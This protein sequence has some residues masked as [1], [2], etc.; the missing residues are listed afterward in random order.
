M[1]GKKMPGHTGNKRRTTT[2]LKIITVDPKNNILVIKGAIP[3]ANGRL[4][5]I[6]NK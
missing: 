6:T 1:K 3:G 2:G 4:V 5:E